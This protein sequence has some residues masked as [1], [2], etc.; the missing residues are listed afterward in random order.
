[1]LPAGHSEHKVVVNQNRD[2]H[3]QLRGVHQVQQSDHRS[4]IADHDDGFQPSGFK[5]DV[6]Q[7]HPG[8]EGCRPPM[9][10]VN[11]VQVRKKRVRQAHAADIRS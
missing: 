1:V 6:G 11:R 5:D 4:P 10:G 3:I 2:I 8:G 9:G 7:R